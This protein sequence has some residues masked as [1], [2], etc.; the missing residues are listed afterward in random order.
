MN[1]RQ[2]MKELGTGLVETFREAAAPLVEKDLQKLTRWADRWSGFVYYPVELPDAAGS[3]TTGPVLASAG[4]KPVLAVKP[5]GGGWTVYSA[6]CPACGGLLHVLAYSGRARCFP[7]DADYGL[8]PDSALQR[9]PLRRLKDG[10]Y[11]VG[12]PSEGRRKP[13]A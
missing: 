2:F 1:R 9:L 8:E 13:H 4:G 3:R 12:L 5:E 7:C 10:G 11:A 6:G